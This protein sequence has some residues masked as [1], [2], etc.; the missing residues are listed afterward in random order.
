MNSEEDILF[1]E[2]KIALNMTVDALVCVCM[3][4]NRGRQCK[5]SKVKGLLWLCRDKHTVRLFG[6]D[7]HVHLFYAIWLDF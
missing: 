6:R 4:R 1:D 5:K 2:G 3:C 7:C